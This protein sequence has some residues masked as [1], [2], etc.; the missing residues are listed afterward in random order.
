[1]RCANSAPPP[2]AGLPQGRIQIAKEI[3]TR[4][5]GTYTRERSPQAPDG[6]MCHW[7]THFVHI[8]YDTILP[9]PPGRD[10]LSLP[11]TAT[12]GT[13]KLQAGPIGSMQGFDRQ[14]LLNTRQSVGWTLRRPV[15]LH[16]RYPGSLGVDPDEAQAAT[17]TLRI[18]CYRLHINQLRLFQYWTR[19]G[20]CRE[21]VMND[22][23]CGSIWLI[24]VRA[25]WEYFTFLAIAKV[26]TF[27]DPTHRATKCYIVVIWEYGEPQIQ[28]AT[29]PMSLIFLSTGYL[30]YAVWVNSLYIRR[31]QLMSCWPP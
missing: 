25:F 26:G 4:Y 7:Y 14:L 12:S 30:R 18:Y 21:G 6:T 19:L 15:R 8:H 1:M 29:S 2:P 13:A 11:L 20:R 22:V 17:T 27:P 5:G 23:L 9:M 16:G 31:R 24:L 3:P 28:K 10:L